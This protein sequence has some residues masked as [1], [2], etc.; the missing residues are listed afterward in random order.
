MTVKVYG[1]YPDKEKGG[2]KRMV[3]LNTST[4][5][6]S[7][8]HAA[9]YKKEQELGRK[10]KKNEHVDHSN[11][12]KKDDSSSNLKVMKASDNIAK[13]NKNRKKK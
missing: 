8:T 5:K 1:P 10:L 9:R 4:G 6:M 3:T 2:R 7:S 11:N 13:G 12:N